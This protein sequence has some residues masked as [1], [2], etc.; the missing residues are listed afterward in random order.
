MRAH[1]CTDIHSLSVSERWVLSSNVALYAGGRFE[2]H[3]AAGALVEQV[4]MGLL[5]VRL[6]RVQASKHHQATGASAEREM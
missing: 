6:H 1:L 3:G 4:T 5:D 2:S